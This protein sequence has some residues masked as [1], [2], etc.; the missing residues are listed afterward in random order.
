[1]EESIYTAGD[2][3]YRSPKRAREELFVAAEFKLAP[4][5]EIAPPA[6]PEPQPAVQEPSRRPGWSSDDIKLVIAQAAQQKAAEAEEAARAAAEEAAIAAAKAAAREERRKAKEKEKEKKKP[7][8][9]Q[10]KEAL[11]EKQLHKLISPIVVKCLSKYKTSMDSSTFKKH[12]KEV[13]RF[14]FY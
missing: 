12:A 14:N 9:P 1:M 11:K 3:G 7:L 6:L 4:I 2:E 8:S 5:V 13:R 10:E